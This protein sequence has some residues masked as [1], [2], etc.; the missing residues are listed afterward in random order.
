MHSAHAS[1]ALAYL[2][3]P[4]VIV[5]TMS[6]DGYHMYTSLIACPSITDY[7]YYVPVLEG[8]GPPGVAM[9]MTVVGVDRVAGGGVEVVV[10]WTLLPS[11]LHC[12]P[13]TQSR[14]GLMLGPLTAHTFTL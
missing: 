12:I 10:L 11:S 1:S 5:C 9:L 3:E 7:T 6:L 2:S 4:T 13:I 8:C 14:A